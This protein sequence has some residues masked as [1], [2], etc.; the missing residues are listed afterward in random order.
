MGV[1]VVGGGGVDSLP[2]KYLSESQ[3]KSKR[4]RMAETMGIPS[5]LPGDGER[6]R[7]VPGRA[8]REVLPAAFQNL[9]LTLCVCASQPTKKL[10]PPNSRQSAPLT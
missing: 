4:T 7:G 9:C 6:V 3:I 8:Q 10:P 1:R 2:P 5:L